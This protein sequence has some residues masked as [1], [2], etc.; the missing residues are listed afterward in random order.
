MFPGVVINTICEHITQEEYS[1]WWD[2]IPK[3][4]KYIIQGNNFFDCEEHIRA[5]E[6]LQHFL[7]QN[8]AVDTL[9][10]GTLDCGHFN[11]YM[12]IGIK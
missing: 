8:Y 1:S 3:G 2:N 5:S 7:E 10:S 9:Y 11:R 4:T 6:S 12:A